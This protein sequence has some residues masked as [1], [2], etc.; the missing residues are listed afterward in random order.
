ME[1]SRFALGLAFGIAGGAWAVRR[2]GARTPVRPPAEEYDPYAE[3]FGE[4][5]TVAT[6]SQGELKDRHIRVWNP[7]TSSH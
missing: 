6:T 1:L 5:V 2:F 7:T 3:P 4:W